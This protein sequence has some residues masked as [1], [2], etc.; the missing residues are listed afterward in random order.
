MRLTESRL[1]NIIRK[2]LLEN[3]PETKEII[4]QI[5][6]EIESG[7]IEPNKEAI[8]Q[9]VASAVQSTGGDPH[10]VLK[11]ADFMWQRLASHIVFNVL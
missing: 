3:H 10:W 8:T 9:R 4:N 6:G 2:V 7:D 11:I 5:Q 1:R